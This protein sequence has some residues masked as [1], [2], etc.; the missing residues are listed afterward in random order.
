LR[1]GFS[2]IEILVVLV[3]IAV[4]AGLLFPALSGSRRRA[5]KTAELN[6][7]R[8]V[9]FAWQLYTTGSA[10]RLLPGYLNVEVQQAWNV[11]WAYPDGDVIEPG[12]D[13]NPALPNHVGAWTWRLMDRLDY[14]YRTLLGHDKPE[15]DIHEIEQHAGEFAATP[16]FGYNGFYVGGWWTQWGEPRRPRPFFSKVELTDGS[17][18]NLVATAASQITKPAEL[19]IFCTTFTAAPGLHA[20]PPSHTPGADMAV[21]RLVAGND[22]WTL[23]PGDR[24]EAFIETAV[25]IGRYNGMPATCFADAHVDDLPLVDLVDQRLWIN[26]AKQVG[27]VPARDFT[28]TPDT[29]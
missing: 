4:L 3:V 25:P 12:P 9:G 15:W 14:D 7:L 27:D 24:L 2:I 5:R 22:R 8:Q 1:R 29:Y 17:P 26:R 28:H 21:P 19:L 20:R 10:E 23:H 18:A 16:G 13:Y 6:S 11:A